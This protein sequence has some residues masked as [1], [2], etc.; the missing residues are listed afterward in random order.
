MQYK[1]NLEKEIFEQ[2][3]ILKN[4]IKKCV[5]NNQIVFNEFNNHIPNLEK[6]DKIILVGC[7][8]SYNIGSIAKSLFEKQ[9]GIKIEI[10]Y[11]SEME[12]FSLIDNKTLVIAM[13]QSGETSDTVKV[14]RNAKKKKGFTVSFV[15]NEKSTLAN[16]SDAFIYVQAGEEIALTATKSF[17]ATLLKLNL[18]ILYIFRLKKKM[19]NNKFKLIL[20]DL[21]S[22]HF[23]VNKV[24]RQSGSIKEIAKKY[25]KK[26]NFIFLGK[27]SSFPLAIE[28]ALKFKETTYIHAEGM[29]SEEFIHG[30]LAIINNGFPVFMYV[31]YDEFYERNIEVAK[32]IKKAKGKLI[33]VSDKKNKKLQKLADDFI[34]IPKA[35][36][37]CQPI[38]N[39]ITAQLLAFEI[40]V[41][42]KIKVDKPR[43]LTK[44]VLRK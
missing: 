16:I 12:D 21:N 31:P 39:V 26:E 37:I 14:I 19:S 18:F 11:A 25:F 29:L 2:P 27:A 1:Y 28:S 20:D 7:G 33:I 34:V 17:T 42:K 44:F 38:L 35:D 30:P 23:K 5:I 24:L 10:A 15:N 32:K 41:L 43:N 9:I 4:I 40:A 3:D 22:L 6:I 36:E 13:S 8:S